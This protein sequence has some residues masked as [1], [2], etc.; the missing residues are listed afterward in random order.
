MEIDIGHIVDITVAVCGSNA[1]LQSKFSI[2][3]KR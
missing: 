1:F 3:Q 2:S